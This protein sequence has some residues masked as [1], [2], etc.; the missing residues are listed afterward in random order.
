MADTAV[1]IGHVQKAALPLHV[2]QLR[3]LLNISPLLKH[4]EKGFADIENDRQRR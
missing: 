2:Q 3:Q 1:S 4:I